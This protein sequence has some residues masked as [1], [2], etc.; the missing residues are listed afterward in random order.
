MLR[1]LVAEGHAGEIAFVHYART[2]AEACYRDELA[3]LPGVRV[4]H[5]YTRSDAGDLV[6]RFGAGASGRRD[7]VA[8]CGVRLRANRFGRRRPEPL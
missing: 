6:G 8:G 5:G 3:A 1:T 4:L 2:A 7:A